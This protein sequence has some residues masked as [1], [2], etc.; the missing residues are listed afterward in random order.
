VR[1]ARLRRRQLNHSGKLI[2]AKLKIL[3]ITKELLDN[4]MRLAT[5]LNIIVVLVVV[6]ISRRGG[7]RLGFRK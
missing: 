7:C 3:N 2:S 5:N 6:I 4:K 1:T